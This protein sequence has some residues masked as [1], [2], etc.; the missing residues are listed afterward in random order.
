MKLATNFVCADC[1]RSV[2]TGSTPPRD[3]SGTCSHCG[4][5]LESRAEV[6]PSLVFNEPIADLAT[7][8]LGTESM[9]DETRPGDDPIPIDRY[10]IREELGG[11]GF[12][13]VYRAYDPRLDR[14]VALKV[15]NDQEMGG[16]H[17]ERFFR[18]AQAAARLDHPHIVS[19]HDAGRHHRLSWIAYQYVRGSS[20]AKLCREQALP[21]A[22]SAA[23]ARALADALDYA[24]RHGVCH[25]D[26]KPANV[27]IDDEGRPRLTDFGLARRMDVPSNLTR[28]GVV[29]GTPAYMSPE[30]AAGYGNLA[31]PRSDIYSLG[32]TLYE[33]L[34][35]HRPID[36]PSHFPAWRMLELEQEGGRHGHSPRALNSRI[37]RPLDRICRK[38]LSIDPA[39][40]YGSAAEFGDDLDLWLHAPAWSAWHR[41]RA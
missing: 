19:V 15:L 38:A 8:G 9:A 13:K 3:R 16:R 36:L 2:D 18:E 6:D 35:G 29:V 1:L 21:F 5:M 25:R 33:L 4:G 12:G 27:L 40:R 24:H 32:V 11:G 39:D 14:D 30:Q 17:L 37:P 26:V 31:D 28:D 20:L 34:S 23:I 41:F 10:Q 7:V 22:R